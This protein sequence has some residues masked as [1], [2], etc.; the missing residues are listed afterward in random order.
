MTYATLMVHLDVGGSN[1]GRLQVAGDL[2]DRFHAGVVGIAACQPMQLAYADGYVSGELIE[3]DVKAKE[4]AIAAAEAE[5][6][7]AFQKRSNALEWRSTITLDPLSDFIARE[8]RSADFVITGVDHN[9]SVFDAS[10][11]VELGDLV[12]RIGRPVLVVPT[13]APKIGF[14]RILVGWKDTRETRRAVAD[15]LPLLKKATFVTVV[16]I[17]IEHEMPQARRHLDQV[18]EWL[19]RHGVAAESVVSASAGNDSA[20]LSE[21]GRERK[22]DL[23]VAGAYGHNRL[24]EWMLGGVTRD[25]LLRPKGC[26]FVSH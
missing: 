23:L 26:A 11:H 14:D 8:A 13:A 2:A 9:S 22:A 6:R 5:F 1:A 4:K 15:A 16:E 7:D 10:R 17:A 21:I 24:R 25:L 20:R 18:V 3:D 19:K 12:M